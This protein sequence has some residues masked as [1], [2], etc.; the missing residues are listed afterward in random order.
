M[1]MRFDPFR[2]LDSVAQML[3]NRAAQSPS[4]IPMDAYRDGDRFVVQF[5]LP[6][7]DPNSID[8]TVE[9]NVLTV[10]ADREWR[11]SDGQEVL[12]AE[13]PQ[14]HFTRQLFLGEGLDAEGVQ[15]S[16]DR[17]VLSIS[18]PVAEQAKPRKIQIADAGNGA[19]AITAQA[20]DETPQG[21]AATSESRAEANA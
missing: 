4:S 3:T 6:G 8:L 17:G 20:R 2:E 11:P 15:A 7:V 21:E 12:I 1:L 14:G 5:D 18:I 10:Q 9:Q 19:R 13:R 16:Y